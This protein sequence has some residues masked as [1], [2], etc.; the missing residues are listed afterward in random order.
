MFSGLDR[1]GLSINISLV[2]PRQFEGDLCG[3]DGL[4]VVQ[5][6][7]ICDKCVVWRRVCFDNLALS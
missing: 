2:S 5:E 3:D 4:S 1:F 7:G 6:T